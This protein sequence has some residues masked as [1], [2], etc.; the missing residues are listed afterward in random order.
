M[1]SMGNLGGSSTY[2]AQGFYQEENSDMILQCSTGAL[3]LT[4]TAQTNG[5]EIFQAGIIP[6]SA[7]LTNYCAVSA[8]PDPANCSGYVN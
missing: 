3:S 8:F 6:Q 7:E 5:E 4:A 2:C 1:F